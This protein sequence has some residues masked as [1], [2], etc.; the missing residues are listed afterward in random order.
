MYK[1]ISD[2]GLFFNDTSKDDE[3]INQHLTTFNEDYVKFSTKIVQTFQ[4][5][6]E[7]NS[8]I[9]LNLSDQV[10]ALNLRLN[11]D[12]QKLKQQFQ[13]MLFTKEIGNSAP[14]LRRQQSLMDLS[15]HRLSPD[16]FKGQSSI[17]Y[18]LKTFMLET[19]FQEHGLTNEIEL[20]M[21]ENETDQLQYNFWAALKSYTIGTASEHELISVKRKTIQLNVN[22]TTFVYLKRFFN[23]MHS[24]LDYLKTS[25]IKPQLIDNLS[26]SRDLNQISELQ[27]QFIYKNEIKKL[28]EHWWYLIR[29]NPYFDDVFKKV[30]NFDGHNFDHIHF[31]FNGITSI[32][33]YVVRM[34]VIN[35]L[36]DVNSPSYDLL[37]E[38]MEKIIR[39]LE[40][41]SGFL[42]SSQRLIDINS[43]YFE[44][45]NSM[46]FAEARQGLRLFPVAFCCADSG[47]KNAQHFSANGIYVARGLQEI[48]SNSASIGSLM[49]AIVIR[50]LKSDFKNSSDPRP[51]TLYHQMQ[52][53]P[54]IT[55]SPNPLVI[56]K[57]YNGS[58]NL[59][60]ALEFS[61]KIDSEHNWRSNESHYQLLEFFQLIQPSI[62]KKYTSF[63]NLLSS[64]NFNNQTLLYSLFIEL[65]SGQFHLGFY[66]TSVDEIKS[67]LISRLDI[68]TFQNEEI[69]DKQE[70]LYDF[71]VNS[72]FIDVT[73]CFEKKD[74]LILSPFRLLA[75]LQ[76]VQTFESSE[77]LSD[78]FSDRDYIFSILKNYTT[79]MSAEKFNNQIESRFEVV[80]KLIQMSPYLNETVLENQFKALV[81]KDQSLSTDS[82]RGFLKLLFNVG[83]FYY[84]KGQSPYDLGWVFG[85]DYIRCYPAP[86][87]STHKI[88]RISNEILAKQLIDY[89]GVLFRPLSFFLQRPFNDYSKYQ[90]AVLMSKYFNFSWIFP[91]LISLSEID[92]LDQSILTSGTIYRPFVHMPLQDLDLFERSFYTQKNIFRTT[93][94][95]THMQQS[96]LSLVHI[97][98]N[99]LKFIDDNDTDKFSLYRSSFSNFNNEVSRLRSYQKPRQSSFF[100]TLFSSIF[101]HIRTT[102]LSAIFSPYRP[103]ID[104]LNQFPRLSFHQ[105]LG[106]SDSKSISYRKTEW[107]YVQHDKFVFLRSISSYY[108][109]GPN[110]DFHAL[111]GDTSSMLLGLPPV[112]SN[113]LMKKLK[114]IGDALTLIWVVENLIDQDDFNKWQYVFPDLEQHLWD[115]EKIR[116]FFRN[117]TC[118][119]STKLSTYIR[120]VKREL[121]LNNDF[122]NILIDDYEDLLQNNAKKNYEKA[123]QLW[124]PDF[125][126]SIYMLQAVYQ[127][128]ELFLIS[129]D[130][131]PHFNAPQLVI[132]EKNSKLPKYEF[133]LTDSS[134]RR[135]TTYLHYFWDSKIC[136]NVY[137]RLDLKLPIDQ[138]YDMDYDQLNLFDWMTKFVKLDVHFLHLE[139][140]IENA[141]SN[142]FRTSENFVDFDKAFRYLQ[143]NLTDV[144]QTVQTIYDQINSSMALHE[145]KQIICQFCNNDV[146]NHLASIIKDTFIFL[147]EYDE[148]NR[149]F[150]LK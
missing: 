110:S 108:E 58:S 64:F 113:S 94:S 116:R 103:I 105:P 13:H 145:K 57:I 62:K 46:V 140:A 135:S 1:V 65:L 37:T 134:K 38:C 45:D 70:D 84:P 33:F 60:Q 67:R 9:Q 100:P 102:V 121:L 78:T 150:G 143:D 142:Y 80:K 147:F 123:K 12:V 99:L 109:I 130:A 14:S 88:D 112:Y 10:D 61:K 115:F 107:R 85:F 52:T 82:V 126:G 30:N 55:R 91:N 41:D 97:M 120:F 124:A 86:K 27:I 7:K 35:T 4:Q 141:L 68:L 40:R 23:D 26:Q 111:K 133:D 11:N 125:L 81:D 73:Q 28:P 146:P 44:N 118:F 66:S 71:F 77:T 117:D 3:I 128:F 54:F 53:I 92:Q 95:L 74:Q 76:S 17:V 127:Y 93:L 122:S 79:L 18:D 59:Y 32:S 6:M 56:T 63:Y 131:I 48:G 90:I 119:N 29:K 138:P 19:L 2:L 98:I 69:Q 87:T 144:N 21:N 96:L 106:S 20:I 39:R 114:Y 101:T 83:H 51:T 137:E 5:F 136:Q 24:M 149:K 129:D 148:N 22:D 15:G 50:E 34:S 25:D 42:P 49:S 47:S 31:K 89:S 72:L 75:L 132:F 139:L 16:L 8:K 104:R 36:I 43:I